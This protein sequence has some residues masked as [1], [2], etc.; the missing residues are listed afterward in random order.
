LTQVSRPRD[1]MAVQRD[2]GM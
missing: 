2:G 1:K